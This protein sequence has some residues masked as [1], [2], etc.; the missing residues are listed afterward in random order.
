MHPG[1][2]GYS[3]L[4]RHHWTVNGMGERI[5]RLTGEATTAE[6]ADARYGVLGGKG[7]LDGLGGKGQLDKGSGQGK[8]QLAR[9][10]STWAPRAR[11]SSTRW[12]RS[13]GR[14]RRS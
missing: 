14:L 11:P 1:Q 7:P 2:P 13:L 3:W 10:S 9:G 5:S 8:A 4:F 12:A 6:G